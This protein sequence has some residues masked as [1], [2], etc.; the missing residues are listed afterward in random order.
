MCVCESTT[1]AKQAFPTFTVTDFGGV[2]TAFAYNNLL[3]KWATPFFIKYDTY[4]GVFFLNFMAYRNHIL[5][6]E[7]IRLHV[8][9]SE[10]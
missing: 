4:C 5:V 6:Y 3:F 10:T 1:I 2:Q 9:L 8:G 7:L